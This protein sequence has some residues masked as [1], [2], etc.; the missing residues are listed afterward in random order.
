[1]PQAVIA[2]TAFYVPDQVV[3]NDDLKQYYDTSD[4]WIY[5]RSGIRERRWIREGELVGPADLAVPAVKEALARAGKTLDDVEMIVFATLSPEAYF[6][7]S[8][9]F[10]QDK[11]G[12]GN[13]P[14]FDIRQQCSGFIYGLSLAEQYVKRGVHKTVVLVG[15][16]VQSTALDYSPDGRTMGVLF[17]DGAGAVVITAAPDSE[18]RGIVTTHLHA[19]GKFAKELWLYEPTSHRRP[20]TISENKDQYPYMNGREVFKHAVTR[21]TE[22]ANEALTAAGWTKDEVDVYVLHQANVRIVQAVADHFGVPF[23]KFYNNIHKYGNTTAASIPICLAEA[24]R[25]G[26]LKKGDR[27]LLAAFGSGFTWAS[28]TL[29]W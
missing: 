12:L 4:E 28:A 22:A 27:V 8:G 16:E 10:L 7:G 26:R 24:E 25:E 23:E 1:M 17:G 9:V 15:G 29:V 18:T 2:G 19:Q 13:I 6:P 21:M 5:E 14:C 20:R 3:K 11:L